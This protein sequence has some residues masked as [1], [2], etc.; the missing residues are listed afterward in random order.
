MAC[1]LPENYMK[2]PDA[3]TFIEHVPCDWQKSEL[4][5][6]VIGDYVVM[7]RQDRHSDNWYVGSITDEEARDYTLSCAFLGEGEWEATIYREAE[8]ADWKRAPYA[9]IIESKAVT[10]DSQLPIQMA[11]GGG[12]AIE[13]IKK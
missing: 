6:A 4:Q 3:F 11:A 5:D 8:G 2:P 9:N 10:A 12:F 7:A 13:F 1:D